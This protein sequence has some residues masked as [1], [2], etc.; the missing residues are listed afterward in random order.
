MVGCGGEGVKLAGL[1][2]ESWEEKGSTRSICGTVKSPIVYLNPK[3]LVHP[4]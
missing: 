2:K 4:P 1:K 3:P